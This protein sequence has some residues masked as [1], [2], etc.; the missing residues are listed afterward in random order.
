MNT[1]GRQGTCFVWLGGH[2]HLLL[3]D[4]IAAS[5]WLLGCMEKNSCS[6]SL[7]FHTCLSKR[8]IK[9]LKQLKSIGSLCPLWNIRKLRVLEPPT[10]PWMKGL[11]METTASTTANRRQDIG[12]RHSKSAYNIHFCVSHIIYYHYHYSKGAYF[13]MQAKNMLCLGPMHYDFYS[14]PVISFSMVSPFQLSL[15]IPG[16]PNLATVACHEQQAPKP[17]VPASLK[18]SWVPECNCVGEKDLFSPNVRSNA[19]SSCYGKIL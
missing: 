19:W 9:P 15:K 8:F 16:Q 17:R 3:K 5:S 14:F 2:S 1:C 6:K 18:L 11:Q 4:T 13:D 7:I 12:H 10:K